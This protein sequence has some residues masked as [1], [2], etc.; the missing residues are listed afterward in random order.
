[1][2]ERE[3]EDLLWTYPQKFV[4][5]SLTQFERQPSSEVGRADLVFIDRI[6]RL[7]VV[8][9]KRGTLERGA[10]LQ[11]VDYFGMMKSRLPNKCVELMVV[12]NRIPV[13]RRLACEQYD[14][15][16]M[17]I[18]QKKFR[19]VAEEVGYT[20]TSESL[21][22]E[23]RIAGPG[24]STSHSSVCDIA[25]P[26]AGEG[27]PGSRSKVQKAWFHWNNRGRSYFLAFVNA[28]GSCSMRC[29][30]AE[31]G[32]FVSK[33]YK[34]GDFQESFGTYVRSGTA[35]Y[36]SRQPNLERDCKL[37]LPSSVL[38]ELKQQVQIFAAIGN[39]SALG[40]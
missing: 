20:F 23:D 37:K 7:L 9:L 25:S 13:E 15:T 14:V 29:F 3:M 21:E 11:L 1:M 24:N 36:V 26:F 28:K 17:E 32:S 5:E 10:I 16:A 22:A 31:H 35:V 40:E 12:A 8:E 18:P 27:F 2:T 33:D 34:A 4:N 6:G 38:F 30:E 19:D 39:S